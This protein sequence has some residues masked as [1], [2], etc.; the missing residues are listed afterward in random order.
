V[1]EVD[2]LRLRFRSLA[3]KLSFAFIA[4]AVLCVALQGAL[5]VRATRPEV[6]AMGRENLVAITNGVLAMC[7]AQQDLL[8]QVLDFDLRLAESTLAQYGRITEG[9]KVT[10]TVADQTTQATTTVTVPTWRAGAQPVHDDWTIVDTVQRLAPEGTTCTIFQRTEPGLLRVSTNVKKGDGSRAVGTY[11]PASSPVA[12]TVL[13]GQTYQGIANVMGKPYV[14][15]YKPLKGEAGE[16]IG[17]LYV[18]VP[19][20][21]VTSLRRAIMDIKVGDTGYV[22]VLDSKGNYVISK[23]GKRDGENILGA[24]DANGREFIKEIVDPESQARKT[25]WIEYPWQNEGEKAARVKIVRLAYFEPWNWVIGAGSYVDEFQKPVAAVT[26]SILKSSAAAL[27]VAAVVGLWIAFGVAKPIRRVA[28]RLEAIS[29]G[30]ADLTQELEVLSVDETGRLA[31]AFNRFV[32]GLA[33]MVRDIREATD[34]VSH[35]AQTTASSAEAAACGVQE[36]ATTAGSVAEGAAQQRASLTEASR[37]VGEQDSALSSLAGSA[38]ALVQQVREASLSLQQMS[39]AVQSAA[40]QAQSVAQ[41]AERAHEAAQRGG[42]MVRS[43]LQGMERTGASAEESM[44]RIEHLAEKSRAIGDIVDVIDDVSEQTNLL[45]LNAAIEAARAG[46]HGKGFAVVADEVRKLAERATHSADEIRSLIREVQNG[47]AEAVEC[48]RAGTREVAE[49]LALAS[50]AGEAIDEIVG[51]VADAAEAVQQISAATEQL[52]AQCEETRALASEM[53]AVSERS[54]EMLAMVADVAS[55]VRSSTEGACQLAE[56][57]AA[58]AEQS[59]A[60]TEELAAGI[61]E[62]TAITQEVSSAAERVKDMVSRFR[63]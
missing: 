12:Q 4:I 57:A 26:R 47:V 32:A 33:Q 41:A 23:D 43:S 37:L 30:G 44:R 17:A 11:I 6:T 60:A 31:A 49:G 34:Q 40:D 61:E 7:Q 5:A 24:K 19:Q 15:L 39:Q 46:E 63:V 21:S 59:S 9:P 55:R 14:A 28:E 45:A 13:R 2:V 35:G 54:Q 48:Q 56:S 10:L 38:S 18:G 58:A 62:M 22:Y 1:G 42:T 50:Q 52:L 36:I 29:G 53:E 20:E 27:A 16:V 51:S 25:G 8:N 3:A